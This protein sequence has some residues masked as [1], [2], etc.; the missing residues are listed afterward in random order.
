MAPSSGT[1]AP[2]MNAAPGSTENANG[3]RDF[4]GAAE[5][6]HRCVRAH[7]V[8]R[9]LRVGR[10]RRHAHEQSGVG[11]RRRDD[12]DAHAVGCVLDRG[13]LREVVRA[14]PSTR[15]TRRS[16]ASRSR[17]APSRAARPSRRRC[18]RSAGCACF[19][20]RNGPLRL[21]SSTRCH[22]S[23]AQST[24]DERVSMAR[25]THEHVEAAVPFD[26]RV[27]HRRDLA[28]ARDVDGH[29]VA[30]AGP[31]PT[32]LSLTCWARGSSMSATTTW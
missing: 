19:M 5:P 21:T 8:D 22:S 14:R 4:F 27:E 1:T 11:C 28:F 12:V 2:L 26:D 18:A 24:T 30:R 7:H 17:R 15:S 23:S 6:A 10:L 3:R 29:G 32:R 25:R 9:R 31:R 13:L 20:H 16:P